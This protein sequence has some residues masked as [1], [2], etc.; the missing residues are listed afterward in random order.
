MIM[1]WKALLCVCVYVWGRERQGVSEHLYTLYPFSAIVPS[2]CH[3]AKTYF[4]N[5]DEHCTH[6]IHQRR[7]TI[8]TFFRTVKES[9]ES[10]EEA[11]HQHS[12]IRTKNNV[13]NKEKGEFSDGNYVTNMGLWW[14]SRR[15]G[16][17][18]RG[19]FHNIWFW[20]VWMRNLAIK[21]ILI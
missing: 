7:D 19:A 8:R 6:F 16:S 2:C 3:F 10:T 13:W 17:M 12:H 9:V 11:P 4:E 20:C 18:S 15:G 14:H 21:L 1:P 5:K